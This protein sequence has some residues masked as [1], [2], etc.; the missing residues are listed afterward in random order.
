[1]S[2]QQPA[3]GENRLYIDG[4]LCDAE[5][6][7]YYN[8]L[9]PATETIAGNAAD[10]SL[11]DAERALSAARK[12]FDESD[13]STNH[14]ARLEHLKRFEACIKDNLDALKEAAIC[15]AGSTRN[16]AQGPQAEGPVGMIQWTLDYLESFQW[17]RDIGEY[18]SVELGM[19][20]KRIVCKEAAGVVAAITPWNFPIQ[21]IL[22]K[23]IPAL[24]A[25]CTVVLKPAPDTPWT[26]TLF[27]RIA[28]EAG[29]PAGVL[30]ILSASDPAE[31]GIF[32]SEDKRVDV[33]SFTGSTPVGKEIMRR[34][35]ATVKRVF[36]ELGGKSANIV[37]D[38]A[39]L[40]SALLNCLAVC[41]HAGQGC[42][43][44]T[45]LLV[46]ENKVDESVTL[47]KSYFG[48]ITFGDQ[49]APGAIMGPL[50]NAKQHEKVLGLIEQGK[51]EGAQLVLGGNKPDQPK[52]GYWV[53]PTVFVDPTGKTCVAT[54]EIFGPVLT[55][56]PYKDENDAIR[57]ANDSDFGLGAGVI[58]ASEE[59]SVRVARKIRAGIVNVNGGNF[60]A[61]DA[62]FGGYKQSGVGREMGPEGI[63]EY[64]ETKTIAIG[65]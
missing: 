8:N 41:Y 45:R 58:S 36:L 31:I 42:V 50:I 22:A 15:E 40:G 11:N 34:G 18:T 5:N 24:A 26:A 62:P 60:L 25:G 59:R 65:V 16:N 14:K 3:F 21:I 27:G 33:V 20:S 44:A 49:E 28:K 23:V 1:M 32:L 52:K 51:S 29:L 6:R 4:E 57:I 37:L 7:R 30:N 48:M 47:L 19:T 63:E 46:P 35:S 61:P 43:I 9:N 53:E 10:A 17:D 64:L 56:I 13:W 39:D 38:D 55:V 54:Q 2:I 12:A